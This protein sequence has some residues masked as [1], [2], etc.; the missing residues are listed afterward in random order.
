MVVHFRRI[1]NGRPRLFQFFCSFWR[2]VNWPTLKRT[3]S[4]CFFLFFLGF[5]AWQKSHCSLPFDG[6]KRI[7]YCRSSTET[8]RLAYAGQ[9]NP[10]KKALSLLHQ[11][12]TNAHTHLY[13][14]FPQQGSKAQILDEWTFKRP[15]SFAL[16]SLIKSFSFSFWSSLFFP[17]QSPRS[18]I[19]GPS[20][21]LSRYFFAKCWHLA[22][23]AGKPLSFQIISRL[24]GICLC[25]L[26]PAIL[27]TFR[28][29]WPDTDEYNLCRMRL[30]EAI[31]FCQD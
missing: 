14:P 19:T 1:P 9:L 4:R 30:L 20:L 28:L 21:S 27:C 23:A 22:F 5:Q 25:W 17:L 26:M 10:T 29:G 16:F 2:V 15:L 6:S 24:L 18:R 3:C 13:L 31:Q 8:I 11:N 7:G 12:S